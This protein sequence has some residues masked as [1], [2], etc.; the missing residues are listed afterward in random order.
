MVQSGSDETGRVG[1]TDI[2][3]KD[4]EKN[5]DSINLQIYLNKIYN[6]VLD[7]IKIQLI[8]KYDNSSHRIENNIIYNITA[9]SSSC[10]YLLSDGG[11]NTI[12]NNNLSLCDYGIRNDNSHN[13]VILL[14]YHFLFHNHTRINYYRNI[15]K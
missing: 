3:L 12:N 14:N 15:S 6:N 2:C 8:D 5:L 9:P 1:F 11:S 7:G 10:I 4:L 13:N